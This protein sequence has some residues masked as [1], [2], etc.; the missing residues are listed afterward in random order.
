MSR[1]LSPGIRI[2]E[3]DQRIE[4]QKKAFTD[5]GSGGQDNQWVSQGVVWAQVR[6]LTGNE[7]MHSDSRAAEGGYRIVIRN[8]PGIDVTADW[9]A[10][11]RGRAMNIRFPQD[12]GPRDLYLVM[13]AETGVAT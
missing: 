12:N 1:S 10:I 5:N 3:L 13:D 6:A 4:L 9:R 2:G 11:W 8:R 7:R